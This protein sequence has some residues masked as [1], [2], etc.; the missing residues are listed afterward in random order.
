LVLLL[1]GLAYSGALSVPYLWDDHL[2]LQGLGGFDSSLG[3]RLR[4]AWKPFL[5]VYYRP[6]PLTLI[7]LE[8]AAGDFAPFVTHGIG[9][10]LF[11]GIVLALMA[12]LRAEQFSWRAAVLSGAVF[13]TLPLATEAVLW[14]SARGDLLVV[15]FGLGALRVT[16]LRFPLQLERGAPS[17]P[18]EGNTVLAMA[19]LVLLA[20]LSKESGLAVAGAVVLRSSWP[21]FVG[22]GRLGGRALWALLPLLLAAL[23]FF[24]RAQLLPELAPPELAA[25]EGAERLVLVFTTLA[26]MLGQLLWP[27]VPDLAIGSRAVSVAGDSTPLLG[28]AAVLGL[29]ALAWGARIGN[30]KRM[31]LAAALLGLFLLPASNLIPIEIAS[32]TADRYLVLPALAVAMLLCCA[33]DAPWQAAR[34]GRLSEVL[35]LACVALALGGSLGT[36]NRVYDWQEEERFLRTLYADADSGNGQPALVLGAWLVTQERCEEA[37]PLLNEA[38]LLLAEEGRER[39]EA[40]ARGGLADCLPVL[41]RSTQAVKEARRAAILDPSYPG[42]Q[43]RI[44]RT[45]RLAGQLEE[46]IRE[47]E[48][49]LRLFPRDPS[50]AAELS[51]SLA[52]ELEFEAAL[53]AFAEARRRAGLEGDSGLAERMSTAKEAA[54]AAS[55]RI[56]SGDLDGYE[57]LAR[58][59]EEWGN[60]TRAAELRALRALQVESQ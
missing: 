53:S 38:V 14:T 24:V 54:D 18:D 43:E 56:S 45:M 52:S 2:L 55:R 13:G 20:L 50:V 49:A 29:L 30:I 4:A 35:G 5:G 32:L 12:W 17:A 3:D 1:V 27:F 31:G 60:P 9:L 44:L 51:R 10:G 7:A 16:A 39:S 6:L 48:L 19:G 40:Q 57:D 11:L 22:Q 28:I 59:A 46:A 42:A 41:G 47:G 33:L 23:F 21:T 8:M 26:T 37:L 36:W 25:P 34:G 15:L 58:L